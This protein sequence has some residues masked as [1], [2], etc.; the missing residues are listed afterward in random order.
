[1]KI[2]VASGKGGT[3]KTMIS[4]NLSA[5]LSSLGKDVL[6]CDCDVEEP[7]GHLFLKP[8]ISKVEEFFTQIPEVNEEKCTLCGK[9][10]E[11]CQFNAI[12]IVG[13]KVLVFN[14]LC[15]SCGGCW[16]VCPT[17][18]IKNIDDKAGDIYYG[19]SGKILFRSGSQKVGKSSPTELVAAVKDSAES[20]PDFQGTIFFD[21]PPG[22]TCPVV[23]TLSN[24]DYTI[25]VTE[26]TPFGLNDL[27]IAVDLTKKMNL[28]FGVVIN[29]ST[30]EFREMDNFL[31]S[32]NIT[33]LGKI[34][35]DRKIASVISEGKI[36]VDELPEV[37]SYYKDIYENMI[38][39]MEK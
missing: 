29:R 1:M 10:E 34:P 35:D 28:K 23:E 31:K 17:S 13:D 30:F 4:V 24:T 26:P 21:S 15:H 27:K 36:V 19:K 2:S 14:D 7:N 39:E 32:E 16:L 5:Y 33:I 9:C 20:I 12:T 11:I 37:K 18:A 22:A 6:Y 3:G 25:L 38:K 8:E